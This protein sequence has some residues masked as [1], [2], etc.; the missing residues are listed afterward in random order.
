M[1]ATT[2][3]AGGVQLTLDRPEWFAPVANGSSHYVAAVQDKKGELEALRNASPETW[4]RLT[5]L[6]QVVGPRRRPAAYKADWVRQ[7]I[8]RIEDAVGQHPCFLDILRLRATDPATTSRGTVPVLSA[9][10]ATARHRKLLCVPVLRIDDNPAVARLIRDAAALD[11]RGVAIRYPLLSLA[12]IEG[13]TAESLLKGTLAVVETE[14]AG[15]DL[16]IDLDELTPEQDVHAED[17]AERVKE[18]MFVGDWRSVVL[19]GTSMP[20][21]LGG[22]IAEGTIGELPRREWELWSSLRQHSLRRLPT[23]GDYVIQHPHPAREEEGGGPSMRANIRYTTATVTL[24]VR[25]RGPISVEGRE[26][27]RALCR[28]LVGREEFTG[29]GYSWGDA[30]IADCASGAIEP[31][32]NNAWRGAGSSHHFRLVTEQIST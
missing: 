8:K 11:G 21:M 2:M 24:V 1:Y 3:S 23:Y 28:M 18:L 15:A 6:V 13:Q 16:L 32:W 4:A 17:I 25:G 31:G 14:F 29:R 5:P 22:V 7:R 9:I 26:Q 27:Y 30:Q 20:R 10:H 12:Q 19:L